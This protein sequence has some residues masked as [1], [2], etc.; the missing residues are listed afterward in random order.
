MNPIDTILTALRAVG[1]T[2]S[3][4][5]SGY[6]CNCPAHDDKNPS[7]SV[8]IG[9]DG[10]VLLHCHAGC[11][12]ESVVTAI[13][14]TMKD[15]YTESAGT[16][17]RS[18]NVPSDGYQPKK[19]LNP[20]PKPK[21]YDTAEAA[22]EACDAKL[23]C[24]YTK[25]WP[26]HSAAG[27]I[28]G[29]AVRWD[30]DDGHKT[31]RPIV[32]IDGNW[33][34]AGMPAPTPLYGLPDLAGASTVYV[35]EGEKCAD[36]MRS[37]GFTATTSAHGS[38][39]AAKADWTP[40]AGKDV[41]IVPDHDE[42]G[43]AYARAV[44]GLLLTAGARTV[45]TIELAH[46]WEDLTKGGDIVDALTIEQGD[47]DTVRT[48]VEA[49]VASTERIK[50][51]EAVESAHF[52]PF[53]VDVLPEPVRS[54]VAE[55]AA[56]IGCDPSY[57]A[58]PMLSALASAIGNSC[59]V[60]LKNSW[61]EPAIIWTAIVGESGTAK[62][63]AMDMA[64]RAVHR[65]QNNAYREHAEAMK[66]W[67]VEN[68]RWEADS[69][70]WKAKG[71]TGEPPSK[72]TQPVCGRVLLE[73]TTTEALAMILH[74][75]PRGVLVARDELAGWFNFDQYSKGKGGDVA[76]W[77]QV[78]G[79]RTLTVDRKTSG[80]LNIR[81]A[82]AS[83]TGGIQPGILQRGLGQAN[84]ENGLAA[85]ILFAM[86]P[87]LAKRWTEEDIS[88]EQE[89]SV[90]GL[91]DRLYA[92]EPGTDE[93]GEPG[94]LAVELSAGAKQAWVRYVDEHGDI[95]A[96]LV[97][98]EASASAKL[99][100]YAARFALVF[101]LIKQASVA[102]GTTVTVA[103]GTSEIDIESM[104]AGIRL[105]RWCEREAMRVYAVL[106]ESE[107][108]K[109]T[110]QLIEWIVKKGGE[111]TVRDLN[112]GPRR[113]RKGSETAERALE[114]LVKLG[115]GAWA[116]SSKQGSKRFI[117]K[118]GDGDSGANGDTS[119]HPPLAPGRTIPHTDAQK[120]G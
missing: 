82:T 83:V 107:E 104:E 112:R 95:Q 90:F 86:P 116:S 4:A 74:A 39:S 100:G 76:A 32:L 113:F 73:D 13:G 55:S 64:L 69:K 28:V 12:A 96:D 36:T 62:S 114:R 98:E 33:H 19:P 97:G 20:R 53:P 94:P 79:G 44:E 11:T 15:L 34:R 18:G 45:R 87:R 115:K 9:D 30:F 77:L 47:A 22:I 119:P 7:L 1:S 80:T 89:A 72:P 8:D 93:N 70:Q 26:Y 75:N 81:R 31:Y 37:C 58:L 101:A 5:G 102:T 6:T 25:R 85:R 49:L 3:K 51:D 103:T 16:R 92:L 54:Y 105:A 120:A 110:R 84:M 46:H 48:A 52:S 43:T 2:V 40:L 21:S 14:L 24:K 23:G 29:Y 111:V 68:D 17:P 88:A 78:F 50:T 65:V 67:E 108:E 27:D 41:V 63:P 42:P 60:R 91:F 118:G 117:L 61:H 109:D 99:E 59:T 10:R 106:N 57:V 38:K 35:V 56:A 66:T 71:A